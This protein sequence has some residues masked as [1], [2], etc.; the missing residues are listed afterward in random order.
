MSRQRHGV[1]RSAVPG[2]A[3]FTH[4]NGIAFMFRTEDDWPRAVAEYLKGKTLAA[5]AA[6]AKG[7]LGRSYHDMRPEDW[8][9][10]AAV[11]KALS[12]RSRE[13]VWTPTSPAPEQPRLWP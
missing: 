9:R 10:L 11:L 5:S 2:P 6:I 8:R 13:G 3:H 1:T 12:W 7:A 4:F